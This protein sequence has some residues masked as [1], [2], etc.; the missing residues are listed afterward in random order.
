MISEKESINIVLNNLHKYASEANGEKY[1]AL[2]DKEAVFYGTDATER[3][4]IN[5]FKK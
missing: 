2:F 4:H 3:W 5:E 1:L